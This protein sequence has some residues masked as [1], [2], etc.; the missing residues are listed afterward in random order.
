MARQTVFA[1]PQR[2]LAT[3]RGV[4]TG[5]PRVF[6]AVRRSLESPK[7]GP[8][9]VQSRPEAFQNPVTT[10]QHRLARPRR[11]LTTFAP[12]LTTSDGEPTTH[13]R[14]MRSPRDLAAASPRGLRGGIVTT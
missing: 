9:T 13:Y 11:V 1:G 8:A 5:S 7:C 2:I 3:F 14:P 12:R 6:A 10:V 4:L